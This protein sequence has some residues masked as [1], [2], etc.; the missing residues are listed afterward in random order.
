MMLGARSLLV[1]IPPICY[2]SIVL[3]DKME[4]ER[5]GD[6]PVKFTFLRAA[7]ST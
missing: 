1:G 7:C 2:F 3:R 5:G 4:Q 6:V